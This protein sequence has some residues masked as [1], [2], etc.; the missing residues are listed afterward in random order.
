MDTIDI[1][2][3]DQFSS[4]AWR[5][6]NLY[7]IEDDSGNRIKFIPNEA[8]QHFF[9]NLWYLNVNC[10]SRQHGMTTGWCIWMLDECLFYANQTAGVIAHTIDDA[11]KIFRTKIDYPYQNLPPDLKRAIPAESD[12]A[13]ELVFTHPSEDDSLRKSSI[14]VGTSMRSGTLQY[15]LISEFGKICAKFPD[16]AEEIMTGSLNTVAP[17]NYVTVEST[18]EGTEGHFYEMCKRAHALGLEVALGRKQYTKMDFKFHFYGWYWKPTNALSDAD[19]E[20]VEIKPPMQKYFES[21]EK[22]HGIYLTP[23]QKAWYVKKKETQGELMLR[24]HPS[25]WEEAFQASVTGKYFS[26]QFTEIRKTGRIRKVPHQ[27]GIGVDTYWD[28]GMHDYMTIW[29]VQDIGT[30]IH[31]IDYYANSDTGFK[32]YFDKLAKYR[33]DKRYTYR[34]H[35]GPHDLEVRELGAGFNAVGQSRV[36]TARQAGIEFIVAPQ[37]DVA[38][39]VEAARNILSICYFDDENC[40]SGDKEDNG[41]SCL[42]NFSKVWNERRQQYGDDYLHNWASHASSA[43]MTMAMMRNRIGQGKPMKMAVQERSARGWT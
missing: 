9:D 36:K 27:D 18:A 8:Q 12:T 24:E 25:T 2:V 42:E 7:W 22:K 1:H 28:L 37:F 11:K 40:N 23:N 6:S 43:F 29:F 10:K 41:V 13:Q 33:A 32:H 3:V 14:S 19:T 30:E 5:L 16:K 35:V 21:L 26:E 4:K 34:H 39:Q 31:L 20:Q 17:G 38:D 15:L